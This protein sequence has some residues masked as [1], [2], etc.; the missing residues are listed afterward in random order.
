MWK[1]ALAVVMLLG[2]A[3]GTSAQLSLQGYGFPTNSVTFDHKAANKINSTPC[4]HAQVDANSPYLGSLSITYTDYGLVEFTLSAA[5]LN[6]SGTG[7]LRT[8]AFG[9][10]IITVQTSSDG[11][12]PIVGTYKIKYY[13]LE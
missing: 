8:N 10:G 4:I 11:D 5:G 7:R 2:L 12:C 1:Y 6:L 9:G 3:L 13:S